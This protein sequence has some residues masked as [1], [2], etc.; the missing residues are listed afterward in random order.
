MRPCFTSS[1]NWEYSSEPS[2]AWRVLNWLNT[3]IRTM[4]ITSQIAIFLNMLF[5]VEPLFPSVG[6]TYRFIL[7]ADRHALQTAWTVLQAFLFLASR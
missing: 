3:V 5:K 2:T 6:T 1:R 4:P 7:S